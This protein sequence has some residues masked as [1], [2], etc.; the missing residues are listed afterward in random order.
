MDPEDVDY[1][2][3]K[4]CPKCGRISDQRLPAVAWNY[5]TQCRIYFD[6]DCNDLTEPNRMFMQEMLAMRNAFARK[7]LYHARNHLAD[8]P[9]QHPVKQ[10]LSNM[11]LNKEDYLYSGILFDKLAWR[12]HEYQQAQR[13]SLEPQEEFNYF[14]FFNSLSQVF[15]ID[16]IAE[17]QRF[18]D[19]VSSEDRQLLLNGNLWGKGWKTF[20]RIKKLVDEYP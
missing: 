8:E 3:D 18:L 4:N 1:I 20:Q 17:C 13:P 15:V 5:C 16:F 12:T 9:E 7:L 14:T 10:L 19:S 11:G 6:D 2:S